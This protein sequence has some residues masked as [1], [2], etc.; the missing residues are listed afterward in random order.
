MCERVYIHD[1]QQFTLTLGTQ[2]G[3]IVAGAT[4][5]ATFAATTA[6]VTAGTTGT[7]TW[8]TSSAGTT[9]TNAPTG[10][11]ASVSAVSSNAATVTMTATSS[12]VA[13]SYYFREPLKTPHQVTILIYKAPRE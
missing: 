1:R 13:G 6:N 12:T 4:G 2:S 5:R 9:T 10:I 8:Y 3:T 11:T 7:V